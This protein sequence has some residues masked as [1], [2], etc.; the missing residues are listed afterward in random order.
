MDFFMQ[1]SAA[2]TDILPHIQACQLQLNRKQQG[3]HA[4]GAP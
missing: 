1:K 4:E 3:Y 2:T